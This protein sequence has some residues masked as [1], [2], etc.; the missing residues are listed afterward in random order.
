MNTLYI[1]IGLFALG[2]LIGMYLLSLVL[3]KKETPK[4]VAFI[5]GGFV[6]TALILLIYYTTQNGPGPIESIVLFIVAALGGATMIIR[7]L[8]G[9]S[10]PKWLALGHGLIAVAGFIFLLVYA[11]K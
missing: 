10:L 4:F 6:A 8:M 1:I 5:H 7:D 11:F 9:K 3:Q 2:A